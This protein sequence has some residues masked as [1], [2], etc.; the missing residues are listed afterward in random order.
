[1]R[2]TDRWVENT[3]PSGLCGVI[4]VLTLVPHDLAKMKEPTG[5]VLWTLQEKTVT[6]HSADTKSLFKI[7]EGAMTVSWDAPQKSVDCDEF[8]F[9]S[10]LEGMSEP[11]KK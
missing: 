6:T 9:N 8:V 11:R 3:G 7:E 10:A 4:K 5:P 2:Q 1:M